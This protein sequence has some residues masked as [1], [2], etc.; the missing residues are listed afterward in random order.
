[1]GHV[2]LIPLALQHQAEQAGHV[3]VVLA[4]QDA[5]VVT[6]PGDGPVLQGP[7][8]RQIAVE[9]RRHPRL[10]GEPDAP[11]MALDDG[12]GDAQAQP[13][14]PLLARR[15]GVGLGEPLEDALPEFRLDA[16]A[17]I[18]HRDPHVAAPSLG[19]DLDHAPPPRARRTCSASARAWSSRKRSIAPA[20]P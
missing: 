10:A 7:P 5:R 8:F 18:G 1:M 6:G 19:G 20:V 4:D 14:P 3:P 11:V 9:D 16:A 12:A 17:V 2:H 13:R 15:G